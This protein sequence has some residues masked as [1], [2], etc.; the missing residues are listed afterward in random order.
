MS[1]GVGCVSL[2]S[3]IIDVPADLLV[4]AGDLNVDLL[5]MAFTTDL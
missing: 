5:C 1:E 3:T 2:S 4:R